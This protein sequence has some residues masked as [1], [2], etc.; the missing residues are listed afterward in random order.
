MFKPTTDRIKELAAIYPEKIQSL[1]KVFD[2]KTNIYIDYGNVRPWAKKL[3]WHVDLRRLMQLLKSFDTINEVKFYHGTLKTNP[4]S[5]MLIEDAKHFGY[6]V[7]TKPVKILKLS[8]DASS[9]PANSPELLK[10]FIRKPFLAK[11]KVETIETLNNELRLLNQQ[12]ILEIEDLKSNF[13]VEIGRDLLRDFEKNNIETFILWSGDSD[14][15]DPANQLLTDK[16]HVML[17]ATSGKVASELSD[18]CA[19]GL[20]IY[21]VKKIKEFI[22]Y[23]KE[24]KPLPGI[25]KSKPTA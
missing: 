22:C 3:G 7:R 19:K 2:K 10:N 9:I 18:L 24:M 12:G 25:D 4:Y 23:K 5:K 1:E 14:F 11:L 8:I 16:K 13:D 17:F 20:K 15:E 6:I 21:D